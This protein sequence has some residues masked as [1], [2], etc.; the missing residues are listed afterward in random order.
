MFYGHAILMW[1]FHISMFLS[2]CKAGSDTG[3]DNFR[4]VFLQNFVRYPLSPLLVVFL[5]SVRFFFNV[6]C[7]GFIFRMR[8]ASPFAN[9]ILTPL[10]MCLRA[11][12]TPYKRLEN[13]NIKLD[14][15]GLF[16]T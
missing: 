4:N 12:T 6:E 8:N 16:N 3:A 14:F 9:P 2:F 5:S 13:T 10:K 15:S 7:F 1:H 11:G